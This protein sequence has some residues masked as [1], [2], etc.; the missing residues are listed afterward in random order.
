MVIDYPTAYSPTIYVVGM[1]ANVRNRP[2]PSSSM[3]TGTVAPINNR[4]GEVTS[5][6][7]RRKSRPWNTEVAKRREATK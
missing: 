2:Q 6:I 4:G 7:K 5:S 1:N 3:M